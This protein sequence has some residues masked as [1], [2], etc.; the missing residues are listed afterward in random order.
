MEHVNSLISTLNRCNTSS[1]RQLILNAIAESNLDADM[2]QQFLGRCNTSSERQIILGAIV[3]S[4]KKSTAIHTTTNQQQKN[5]VTQTPFYD[6]FISHASEDKSSFVRPLAEA[7]TKEGLKVW[8]DEFTLKLGDS[9]SRSIDHGLANSRFGVV[10]LSHNFFAKEWP[11]RELGGLMARESNSKKIILPVWHDI[12]RLEME[13]Y[14]PIMAD[15]LAIGSD[16][17]IAVVV[18]EIV[19]VVIPW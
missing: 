5:A 10:V 17:G 13:K 18:Q 1:E 7:L 8:Y 4:N 15:R 9:L 3:K 12:T 6:L 11:Q 16:K 2:L 14:S 19:N